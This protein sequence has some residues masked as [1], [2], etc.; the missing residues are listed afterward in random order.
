VA[1]RAS[2][3]Y[4]PIHA[5]WFD[6]STCSSVP[7]CYPI[8]R[9][10]QAGSN[11]PRSGGTAA[12]RYDVRRSNEA[13]YS[14]ASTT[15]AEYHDGRRDCGGNPR[16]PGRR[17]DGST[18]AFSPAL[19][20]A[21]IAILIQTCKLYGGNPQAYFTDLRHGWALN[22]RKVRLAEHRLRFER[23]ASRFSLVDGNQSATRASLRPAVSLVVPCVALKV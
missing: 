8:G 19:R 2:A 17:G 11:P 5:P 18:D 14:P 7:T 15:R 12:T 23:E 3:F 21:T 1:D 16:R 20:V 4:L 13:A 9:R 6:Q 22:C 10:A